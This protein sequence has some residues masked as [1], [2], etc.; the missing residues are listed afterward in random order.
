V[1][2]EST[3]E[4]ASSTPYAEYSM[5]SVVYSSGIYSTASPVYP[6]S[7]YSASKG[8]DYPAYPAESSKSDAASS[9]GYESVPSVT[10]KP[11]HSEYSS[12]PTGSTTTV[13]TSKFRVNRTSIEHLLISYSY[14]R[15]RLP[16]WSDHRHHHIRCNRLHQVRCEAHWLDRRT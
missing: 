2:S 1:Y 3:P 4:V 9:T 12:V 13:V 16:H 15:R 11:E 8:M 14:L 6:T 10:K 5:S 7:T